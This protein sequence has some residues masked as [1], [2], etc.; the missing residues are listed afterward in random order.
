[1]TGASFSRDEVER[2]FRNYWTVGALNE[3]WQQWPEVF[4]EDVLYVERIY[5]TMRGKA[6]VRDWI[7]ELMNNNQHVHAVLDWYMI[8]GHRVVINMLNRY[9][10][11]EPGGE[12]FDFAGITVLHYAGDGLFNYEEDYWD[13]R[14]AKKAYRSFQNA[15]QQHGD[16]AIVE[17]PE[18]RALRDPWA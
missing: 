6:R 5:G 16:S 15:F 4:T 12:P 1:M 7:L 8:E 17:T 18:R 3:D 14:A 13:L 10:N 11:P 9:Y 2:A